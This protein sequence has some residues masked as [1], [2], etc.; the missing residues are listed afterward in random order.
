[1]GLSADD[2]IQIYQLY[3]RAA[4]AMDF[5]DE[6]GYADCFT[7]DGLMESTAHSSRGRQALKD[8]ISE[9]AGVNRGVFPPDGWDQ[10]K[11]WIGYRHEMTNI[12]VEGDGDTATS[13]CYVG[14]INKGPTPSQIRTAYYYDQ[15]VKVDG[16]WK[17]KERRPVLDR[18]PP[19]V[20]HLRQAIRPTG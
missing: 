10:P 17:I 13:K 7:E 19:G 11:D 1:M 5:G 6:D 14:N 15:L 8:L 3:A 9:V 18:K 4:W 16:Q 12:V 20:T 2:Y